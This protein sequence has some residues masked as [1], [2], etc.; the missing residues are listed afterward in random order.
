MSNLLVPFSVTVK[1]AIIAFWRLEKRERVIL[2]L[3]LSDEKSL[4]TA[5]NWFERAR[6]KYQKAQQEAASQTK[7]S[8]KSKDKGA[9]PLPIVVGKDDQWF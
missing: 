6:E 9:L 5:A 8:R 4:D 7:N 2:V 3:S 1:Q